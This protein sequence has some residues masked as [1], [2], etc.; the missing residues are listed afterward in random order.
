MQARPAAREG[1]QIAWRVRAGAE[2]G[3]GRGEAPARRWGGGGGHL[4]DRPWAGGGGA[5]TRVLGLGRSVP[6]RPG[7]S[8]PRAR[9]VSARSSGNL[10]SPEPGRLGLTRGLYPPVHSPRA[11][12]AP[13]QSGRGGKP[14]Q[15]PLVLLPFPAPLLKISVSVTGVKVT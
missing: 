13:G 15:P 3:G 6:A 11:L 7:L 5:R 4:R 2:R 12:R 8:E 9:T 10:R 14:G 1:R